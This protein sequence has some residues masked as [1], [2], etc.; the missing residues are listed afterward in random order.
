MLFCF[1]RTYAE[2]LVFLQKKKIFF[3]TSETTV[4]TYFVQNNVACLELSVLRSDV[5]D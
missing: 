5:S 2:E 1:V 3:K 4:D